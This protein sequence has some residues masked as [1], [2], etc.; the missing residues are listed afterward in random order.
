MS[1]VCPQDLVTG[2]V[3]FSTWLLEA[4]RIA[5]EFLGLHKGIC[6]PGE[7]HLATS[8]GFSKI[9]MIPRCQECLSRQKVK[10]LQ[11]KLMP[12]GRVDL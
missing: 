9:V 1:R 12:A 6:F 3:R 4:T 8:V 5:Q 11:V 2:K 7:T 10:S